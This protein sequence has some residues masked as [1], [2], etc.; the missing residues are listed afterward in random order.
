MLHLE[1]NVCVAFVRYT[2]QSHYQIG[3]HEG[4]EGVGKRDEMNMSTLCEF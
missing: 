2:M 1:A 4:S 3:G